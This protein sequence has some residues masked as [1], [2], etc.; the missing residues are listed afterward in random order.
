MGKHMEIVQTIVQ[1][2]AR[3]LCRKCRAIIRQTQ[4]SARISA[5]ARC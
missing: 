4:E 5:M 1:T 2:S 3:S